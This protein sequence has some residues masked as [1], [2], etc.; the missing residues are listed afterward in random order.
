ML[1]LLKIYVLVCEIDICIRIH[2][3]SGLSIFP[4]SLHASPLES[5]TYASAFENSNIDTES[6]VLTATKLIHP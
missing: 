5:S 4:V 2:L 6:V 1:M 3:C